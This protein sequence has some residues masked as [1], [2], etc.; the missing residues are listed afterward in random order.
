MPHKRLCG[1]EGLVLQRGLVIFAEQ[2][3]AEQVGRVFA[4]DCALHPVWTKEGGGG[5]TRVERGI[6]RLPRRTEGAGPPWA[7]LRRRGRPFK[8]PADPRIQNSTSF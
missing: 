5:Q 6:L 3:R 4:E 8:A 2:A 1:A 7:M